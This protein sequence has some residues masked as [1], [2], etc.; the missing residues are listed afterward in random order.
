MKKYLA[1][2]YDAYSPSE[3]IHSIEGMFDSLDEARNYLSKKNLDREI[4][5]IDTD[6]NSYKQM[7]LE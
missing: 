7:D 1:L 4:I 5:E 2:H 6:K 3:V